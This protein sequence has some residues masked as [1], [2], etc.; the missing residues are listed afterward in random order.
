MH[1]IPVWSSLGRTR[2]YLSTKGLGSVISCASWK[3]RHTGI[4]NDCHVYNPNP[5]LTLWLNWLSTVT[6]NRESSSHIPAN[7]R[8]EYEYIIPNSPTLTKENTIF[9]TMD[10]E[11]SLLWPTFFLSIGILGMFCGILELLAQVQIAVKN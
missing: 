4:D 11:H 6:P 2:F 8:I 3:E 10:P 9:V 1:I 7:V 5:R